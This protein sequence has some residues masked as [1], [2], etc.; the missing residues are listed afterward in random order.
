[1]DELYSESFFTGAGTALK[2]ESARPLVREPVQEIKKEIQK[3]PEP[4]PVE[5]PSSEGYETVNQISFYLDQLE[6]AL[7]QEFANSADFR[8][9]IAKIRDKLRDKKTDG[10]HELLT[11]L[12]ELMELS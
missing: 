10:I 2:K 11:D 3:S 9:I 12:E 7:F 5:K 6:K 4:I 1:M 8:F